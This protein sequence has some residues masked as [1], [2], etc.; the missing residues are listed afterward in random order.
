MA[1]EGSSGV[2]TWW[3]LFR[4]VMWLLT[5]GILGA[6]PG[7][8]VFISSGAW[9]GQANDLVM[10][11]SII[12]FIYVIGGGVGGGTLGLAAGVLIEWGKTSREARELR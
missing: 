2:N 3:P 4:I 10:M 6:L 8:V 5:G 7:T 1:D 9:K 12:Y 11:G